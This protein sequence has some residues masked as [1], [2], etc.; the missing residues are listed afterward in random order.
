MFAILPQTARNPAPRNAPS[1]KLLQ[2]FASPSI[3]A[4]GEAEKLLTEAVLSADD[5][6]F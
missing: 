4:K 5:S 6:S 3:D 2:L 1:P